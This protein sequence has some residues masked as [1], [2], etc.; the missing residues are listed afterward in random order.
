MCGISGIVLKKQNEQVDQ[1]ILR[2]MNKLIA[3]RG[4]DYDGI[5]TK[6]N[7]GL[8]HRRL[9]IIGLEAA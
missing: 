4:P 2:N 3:H 6:D 1:T 7:I 8:G 5:Y 9:A